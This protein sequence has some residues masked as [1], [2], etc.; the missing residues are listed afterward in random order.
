MFQRH[1][2]M[3]IGVAMLLSA[4]L[5]PCA[6][7]DFSAE[8][9]SLSQDWDASLGETPIDKGASLEEKGFLSDDAFCGLLADAPEESSADAPSLDGFVS[10]S[11][12]VVH[13]FFEGNAGAVSHVPAG[14]DVIL[15]IGT[16][17]EEVPRRYHY[18]FVGWSEDPKAME[19]TYFPGKSYPFAQS[20]RLY[21]VWSVAA[22]VRVD[23]LPFQTT[24]VLERPYIGKSF[25]IQPGTSGRYFILTTGEYEKYAILYDTSGRLLTTS[26]FP[27]ESEDPNFRFVADLEAGTSYILSI[28]L[29]GDST[30]SFGLLIGRHREITYD[31][32]GGMEAPLAVDM[33]EGHFT[34]PYFFPTR[35]GYSFLGWSKNPQGQVADYEPF[36]TYPAGDETILYAVWEAATPLRLTEPLSFTDQSYMGQGL[37]RAVSFTPEV[38]QG[39]RFQIRD[40]T[41][42][43]LHLFD[44]AG[45]PVPFS[46]QEEEGGSTLLQ[47]Y[48]PA[49]RQVYLHLGSPQPIP[50][51]NPFSYTL[52]VVEGTLLR[53]E[54]P[55]A[56]NVP[57]SQVLEGVGEIT[58]SPLVPIHGFETFLGWS[59][60]SQTDGFQVPGKQDGILFHPG[61][62]FPLT[63]ET[64]LHAWWDSPTE[65]S[66]TKT[67]AA[68]PC[69]L[70]FAGS[71]RYFRLTPQVDDTIS[72]STLGAPGTIGFLYEEDGTLLLEDSGSHEEL[73]LSMALEA[74]RTYYVGV[75]EGSYSPREWNFQV[76]FDHPHPAIRVE[77]QDLSGKVGQTMLAVVEA[78]G[79]AL[80]YQWYARKEGAKEWKKCKLEGADTDTLHLPVTKGNAKR[81]YK[82]VVTDPYG[83]KLK[84][85]P[86]HLHL[87]EP[88]QIT[89]EPQDVARPE[90][91]KAKFTVQAT[92][93]GLT[94]Q[95][96]VK[97]R[98]WTCWREATFSGSQ[99]KTIKVPTTCWN[100]GYEY[101]CVITDIFGATLESAIVHL[102]VKS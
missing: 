95:W 22:A 80:S 16:I 63:E 34:I 97:R 1:I 4:P 3:V 43:S 53:Y 55:D 32:C 70:P 8:P 72:V 57:A 5:H 58:L 35:P 89:K 48:L 50:L 9:A 93:E 69:S 71:C 21:A 17:P 99:T 60:E 11:L 102:S 10:E 27:R 7:G 83:E 65:V 36:V 52:E 19:A 96:W 12:P 31:P 86:I 29:T 59:K 68:Y 46:A 45:D 20:T 98:Y 23:S 6:A 41:F 54:A 37:G 26:A 74:G 79:K 42:A 30:G 24:V 40:A 73:Q 38:T 28:H 100:A 88:F 94:Y 66:L 64:T 47:A 90:C 14:V 91:K 13:V 25:L 2:L 85:S 44:E 84:T 56:R 15:G 78:E 39:Y 92:G 33:E 67:P 61:D 62:T 87:E 101:K 51:P 82:C 75:A 76:V 18:D 77:P 81:S 49:G